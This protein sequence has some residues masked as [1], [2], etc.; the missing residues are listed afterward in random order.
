M[1]K[2]IVADETRCLACKQCVIECALA[3][4]EADSVAEA[5]A[6]GVPLQS[7]IRVEPTDAGATAT[8][9]RHCA[10][11]PCIEACPVDAITREGDGPVLIDAETCV[12]C[13]KCVKACPYDS[14]EMAV[15]GRLAIKCDLCKDQSGPACVAGCPTQALSFCKKPE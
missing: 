9:C 14:I 7:R 12:G 5:I 4:S 6:G 11:A 10:E 13:K 3:H 1:T 8:Q 2:I 15:V